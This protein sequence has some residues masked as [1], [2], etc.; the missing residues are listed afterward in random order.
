MAEKGRSDAAANESANV[1]HRDGSVRFLDDGTACIVEYESVGPI[2]CGNDH[3]VAPPLPKH[4]AL[5]M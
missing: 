5:D 2:F 4:I 3:P 1:T